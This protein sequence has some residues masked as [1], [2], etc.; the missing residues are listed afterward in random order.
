[1]NKK[2]KKLIVI[3]SNSIIHRSFHALPPL[4]NKEGK[5][6]NA[7]YGFFSIFLKMI[8]DFEPDF[9]A[10][11]FDLPEPTF[12]HKK[13][14]EY[15][16]QRPAAPEKLYKQIP[17]VKN[18]LKVLNVAIFSKKG[19]EADDLIGTISK[20]V[21]SSN[22]DFETV[23]LSGDLDILQLVDKKTKVYL[24]RGG[25]KNNVLYNESKVQKK[26][27]GLKPEQLDDF[28]GLRGDPSDNIP[29]ISGV[30]QKTAIKLLNKFNNIENLYKQ[31]E[32]GKDVDISKRIKNLLKKEKEKAFLSQFLAK[33]KTD[34]D[35]K[36]DYK[37]MKWGN[38]KSEEVFKFLEELGFKSL[39]NRFQK[40][41]EKNSLLKLL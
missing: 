21:Q 1:M 24:S 31:I 33:I 37:K 7:V 14:E 38:Y 26:Y 9:I 28:R 30:G 19:F 18:L 34:I 3:D 39:I 40:I 32:S 20:K 35:L 36:I 27:L 5:L 10:A 16:A 4:K 15:K 2:N 6:L 25:K 12:R 11:C 23:I 29:G 8:K 22:I 13:Y 41:E 17:I